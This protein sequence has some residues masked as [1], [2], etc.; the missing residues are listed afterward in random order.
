[1]SRSMRQL[2]SLPVALRA[3]TQNRRVGD[4]RTRTVSLKQRLDRRDKRYS[5]PRFQFPSHAHDLVRRVP[6]VALLVGGE[7]K[8]HKYWLGAVDMV[9]MT[10]FIVLLELVR[11]AQVRRY[12]AMAAAGSAAAMVLTISLAFASHATSPMLPSQSWKAPVR[13]GAFSLSGLTVMLN[14][15]VWW[16][17][18]DPTL[19]ALPTAIAGFS[20]VAFGLS[21]LLLGFL[22]VG[23]VRVLFPE[24]A[25]A[26]RRRCVRVRRAESTAPVVAGGIGTGA[27]AGGREG[28]RLLVRQSYTPVLVRRENT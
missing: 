14:T 28:P 12:V 10:L 6:T 15:L 2:S 13:L 5:S 24:V 16:A 1:M 9:H 3:P 23:F 19:G 8:P 27:R 20:V 17:N 26:V 22:A 11:A 7:F 4:K 21:V 25:H 18:I